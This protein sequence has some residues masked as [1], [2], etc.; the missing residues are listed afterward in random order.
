[1]N[2]NVLAV[3]GLLAASGGS[4]GLHE[5]KLQSKKDEIAL[6]QADLDAMN[7]TLAKTQ[8]NLEDNEAAM[9]KEQTVVKEHYAK[10]HSVEATEAEVAAQA[11][12]LEAAKGK[13]EVNVQMM[14]EAMEIVR[15]A[16]KAQ[17]PAT[18]AAKGGESYQECT[19]QTCKDGVA[20]FLHKSG[21]ARLTGAQLTPELN[22]RLRPNFNPQL[23]L[24][25][26][27]DA[28]TPTELAKTNM[29]ELPGYD[30]TAHP[31]T[32][33]PP[34][35]QPAPGNAPAGQTPRAPQ[36]QPAP[37]QDI[38]MG[39]GEDVYVA[40]RSAY[41]SARGQVNA[42]ESQ[43]A[44]YQ[45]NFNASNDPKEKQKIQEALKSLRKQLQDA[46]KKALQLESELRGGHK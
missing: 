11:R 26:D 45:N 31:D 1:M 15:K 37:K 42:A 21:M 41:E 7:A 43:I 22:D 24:P 10:I 28:A 14:T 9:A 29:A 18:I 23:Q 44:A 36:A 2:I 12:L 33:I 13:W 8:T 6:K 5:Y 25:P 30:A 40:K 19:F 4:Y 46:K 35:S 17:P 3:I 39:K 20:V 34:F 16:Y 38:P 27:P 32:D